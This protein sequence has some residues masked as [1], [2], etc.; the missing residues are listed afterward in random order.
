MLELYLE[1]NG[2][3]ENNSGILQL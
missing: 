3:V 2:S 1:E